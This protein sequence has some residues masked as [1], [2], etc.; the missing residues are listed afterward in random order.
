[1]PSDQVKPEKGKAIL[2]Y[3]LLPDGNYDDRSLHA[4]APVRKGEKVREYQHPGSGFL[5]SMSRSTHIVIPCAVAHQSMDLGSCLGPQ[6]SGALLTLWIRAPATAL[7]VVCL[8]RRCVLPLT[9]E[10]H[11]LKNVLRQVCLRRNLTKL[12]L[13]KILVDLQN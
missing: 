12:R 3:N 10:F 13:H 8:H 7:G 5:S 1:M 2:F 4:A 11:Y 9:I 6:S